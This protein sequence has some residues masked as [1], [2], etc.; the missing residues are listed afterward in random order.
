VPEVLNAVHLLQVNQGV[1]D[2]AAGQK[3]IACQHGDGLRGFELG[4]AV[5]HP[6]LNLS[7]GA[8]LSIAV[9]AAAIAVAAGCAGDH[10]PVHEVRVG[11]AA[12]PRG[13]DNGGQSKSD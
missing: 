7:H 6:A 10:A 3:K 1:V 9:G 5:K 8:I 2:S 13:G 4:Q 12:C 11:G